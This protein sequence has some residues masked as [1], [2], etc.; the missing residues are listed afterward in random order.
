MNKKD[1]ELYKAGQFTEWQKS[2]EEEIRNLNKKLDIVLFLSVWN[3]FEKIL[4]NNSELKDCELIISGALKESAYEEEYLQT[5]VEITQNNQVILN[6]NILK[7]IEVMFE[8]KLCCKLPGDEF[9]ITIK[10]NQSK[11]EIR[12]E[13]AKIFLNEESRIIYSYFL[14]NN[15]IE[16]KEI[17]NTNARRNK[18]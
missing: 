11:A 18:I 6:K 4:N 16:N 13:L 8:Y 15:E 2:V 12:E 9:R 3:D 1:N 17:T 10:L 7:E 5:I 14:I